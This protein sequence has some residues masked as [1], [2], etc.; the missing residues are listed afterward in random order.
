MPNLLTSSCLACLTAVPNWVITQ[1]R[2][3][4]MVCRHK[5]YHGTVLV[6]SLG[7]EAR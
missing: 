1:W 3:T 4:S 2:I 7:M 5:M 6:R